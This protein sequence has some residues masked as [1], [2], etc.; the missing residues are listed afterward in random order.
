[1]EVIYESMIY[2]Y[3]IIT[4]K[5]LYTLNKV[6]TENIHKKVKIKSTLFDNYYEESTLCIWANCMRCKSIGLFIKLLIEGGEIAG[7]DMVI[8][9][10]L[11]AVERLRTSPSIWHSGGVV[12]EHSSEHSLCCSA[13][14]G[15]G[16]GVVEL[17]SF[18][19]L[20]FSPISS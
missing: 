15:D 2:F 17:V 16:D 18:A 4:N 13:T 5:L 8:G 19:H 11:E 9:G 7:G 10:G 14:D 1:M 20:S 12:I 6:K 3:T